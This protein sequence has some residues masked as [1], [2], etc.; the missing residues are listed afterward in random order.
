M[1]LPSYGLLTRTDTLKAKGPAIKRF[2]SVISA[3]WAYILAGHAKEAA[4][5]TMKQRPAAA[6]SV[7]N[8]I[9]EFERHASYFVTRD[10][11]S[12]Y[13]GIQD[14]AYWA[15]AIAEM[16]TAKVIP[17]GSAPEKYFTNDFIDAELRPHGR[18]VAPSSDEGWA[19]RCNVDDG[20]RAERRTFPGRH[21]GDGPR[22]GLCLVRWRH[23]GPRRRRPQGQTRRI[24]QPA[25]T[26]RLR[27]EHAPSHHRGD[28]TG[29]DGNRARRQWRC[30]ADAGFRFPARRPGRLAYHY[31][32]CLLPSSSRTSA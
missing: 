12:V 31:R 4:E 15:K 17:A 14:R 24:R 7:K 8:L 10:G 27:Q 13:P 5:A 28:R 6:N 30:R 1:D 29:D 32:E 22:Q 19:Y 25:G 16:Q 9:D 23:H 3:S 21:R 18:S 11:R 20:R 26:E 2:V